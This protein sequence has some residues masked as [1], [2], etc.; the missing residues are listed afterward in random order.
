M[1]SVRAFLIAGVVPLWLGGCS[2]LPDINAGLCGNGIL[3]AGEDCDSPGD[4]CVQCGLVCADDGACSKDGF[5]CGVDDFCHA[6]SGEFEPDPSSEVPFPSLGFRV[7]DVDFDGYGDVVGLN[8]TALN[9]RYGDSMGALPDSYNVATPQLMGFPAVGHLEDRHV[10]DVILP[11]TDGLVA[12]T[13]AFGVP[14]PRQ[15]PLGGAS[16]VSGDR[17]TPY[18]AVHV[19]QTIALFGPS[20]GPN[21]KLSF[22]VMAITS[23]GPVFEAEITDLCGTEAPASEL[24]WRQH[25]L[26]HYEVGDTT[27]VAFTYTNTCVLRV[28]RMPAGFE[29]PRGD[30]RCPYLSQFPQSIQDDC[31]YEVTSVTDPAFV[32]LAKQPAFADLDGDGCPSLMSNDGGLSGL[33][34]YVGVDVSGTCT[35]TTS[36][37]QTRPIAAQGRVIGSVPLGLSGYTSDALVTT[38]GIYA[39]NGT[40]PEQL[41]TSDRPMERAEIG[42]LDDDG[43]LD[44]LLTSSLLPNFDVA[45]RVPGTPAFLLVRTPTVGAVEQT[46]VADFDG[47]LRDDLAYV[48]NLGTAERLSIAYGTANGL[49]PGIQADAFTKVEFMSAMQVIDSGDPI[50][51]VD[52]LIVIDLNMDSGTIHAE[53]TVL[54]GSSQ[55]TMLSFYGPP[56]PIAGTAFRAVVSGDFVDGDIA[57]TGG[58]SVT[59]T[60]HDDLLAF[61]TGI[62]VGPGA[63]QTAIWLVPGLANAKLGQALN[64]TGD[65]PDQTVLPLTSQVDTCAGGLRDFCLDF[66]VFTVWNATISD[67]PTVDHQIV[68]AVDYRGPTTAPHLLRLDPA[69]VTPTAALP[70]GSIIEGAFAAGGKIYDL[71]VVDVDH[72][73]APE[74][75]ASFGASTPRGSDGH[76]AICPMTPAGELA[77]SCVDVAADVLNDPSLEC[78]DGVRGTVRSWCD[79]NPSRLVVVCRRHG[80]TDRDVMS[81]VV[82]LDGAAGAYTGSL[83]DALISVPR[84]IDVL[85]V[86][87]VTGD[88]LDD[89]VTLDGTQGI[90]SLQIYPQ[91]STRDE[92]VCVGR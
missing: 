68:F 38:F 60:G 9:V 56:V 24:M 63:D 48:E 67:D 89:L 8:T 20:F 17:P 31:A 32:S 69:L 36:N 13:G 52:D 90:A 91:R 74:L 33:L 34:E 81:F 50:G 66:A 42:D 61:Q 43:S 84:R 37:T 65:A 28:R 83:D 85:Q 86:S 23:F 77:G 3:E 80:Q 26:V 78:V 46:V 22:G 64:S 51:I 70:P 49:A 62:Q 15:F 71:E 10:D 21:P 58:G 88:Q 75:V 79:P 39:F 55:R 25:E 41:Y 16:D 44:V 72:D 35:I 18:D 19:D 73:G 54:H 29:I 40:A 2:E 27:Y 53:I 14:S 7:T 82:P 47:D 92:K 76:V 6:P 57:V 5:T 87:D 59:T 45:R 12:Y 30:P 4:D 1:T 11:T